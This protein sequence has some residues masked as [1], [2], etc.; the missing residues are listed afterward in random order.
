MVPEIGGALNFN[1]QYPTA[2]CKPIS[3]WL[4]HWSE[5]NT[6][7]TI[8]TLACVTSSGILRRKSQVYFFGGGRVTSVQL[9][10]WPWEVSHS[11]SHHHSIVIIF[12]VYFWD[13]WAGNCLTK[14]IVEIHRWSGTMEHSYDKLVYLIKVKFCWRHSD[15]NNPNV[16]FPC[17]FI[18]LRQ[19]SVREK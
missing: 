6:H 4:A 18:P 9:L 15:S 17:S 2:G 19:I 10:P 3:G 16:H 8:V 12:G 14:S 13:L 5:P 11:Y 1:P 7:P